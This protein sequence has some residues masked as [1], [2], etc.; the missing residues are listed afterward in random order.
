MT[1][2]QTLQVQSINQQNAGF[3]SELA[4]QPIGGTAV[5]GTPGSAAQSF[6]DK[7][8]GLSASNFPNWTEITTLPGTNTTIQNLIKQLTTGD[9]PNSQGVFS[10]QFRVFTNGVEVVFAFKGSSTLA[11]WIDDLTNSGGNAFLQ[12]QPVFNAVFDALKSDPT[13]ANAQF[14]VDGHSLGGGLA[15][16]F[17]LADDLNGYGQNSLP[18]SATALQAIQI[19][20]PGES[21]MQRVNDYNNGN[22]LQGI[23]AR[24]FVETNTAGDI[25]TLFYSTIQKQTYLNSNPTTLPNP[26]GLSAAI[27]SKI[28]L[29][30]AASAASGSPVGGVSLLAAV[31]LGGVSHLIGRNVNL[32][33]GYSV[34]SNGLL[35]G[36][37]GSVADNGL[38]A[39]Q[40]R[41]L[42]GAVQISD[43]AGNTINLQS[44]GSTGQSNLLSV[45]SN[46][47]PSQQY[48]IATDPNT[49]DLQ[50]DSTAAGGGFLQAT[51]DAS[52]DLLGATARNQDGLTDAIQV[53][54]S[55][56]VTS[57]E[58]ESDGTTPDVFDVTVPNNGSV[59]ATIIATLGAGSIVV[60][61]GT[62]TTTIG[63]GIQTSGDLTWSDSAGTT[64][65]FSGD[66]GSDVG[67]LAISGG[68]LGSNPSSSIVIQNF[69][70]ADAQGSSGFLGIHLPETTFL[71]AS[72]N[73]GIDPPAP[74]FIEGSD[75]S[76]TLSVDAPSTSAQSFAVTLSGASPSDFEATVGNTVEQL[77]A[78]GTF[79]VTLAAGETNVSFGLTDTTADNGSSDISS[80]ATLQ[81]AASLPNPDTVSGGSIQTAPLTFSYIP[82]TP[83]TS[84]APN[85]T[86]VIMGQLDT[87]TGNTDYFGDGGSDFIAAGGGPNF[88]DV[89]N[90][91]GASIIGGAGNNTIYGG[92]GND[93]TSLVGSND[94][95]S[96]G[97]GFNTVYGGTGKDTIYSSNVTT[98]A[99]IINGNNGTDVIIAGDG[100]NE[101]YAGTRTSLANAI[102]AAATATA[103]AT[104]RQGDLI[105]VGDG[106]NTIVGS[107][108][109]DFI[110]S[111]DS[112]QNGTGG[113]DVIVLGA[114]NDTYLGGI[115]V[116]QATGNWS[117]SVS[118]NQFIFN[119]IFISPVDYNNPDAQPYNGNF[120]GGLPVGAGNATIFGG[121]G[122]DLLELA[123]GNNYVEVGS[124]NSSVFGGMGNDTI[125]AGSGT[126]LI[127]GGGG[128]GNATIFSSNGPNGT[129][130]FANANLDQ[131]YVTGGSGSAISIAV[132]VALVACQT[133]HAELPM[134]PEGSI[135]P[136]YGEWEN[137]MGKGHVKMKIAEKWITTLDGWCPQRSR[138]QIVSIGVS[139]I[140]GERSLDIIIKMFGGRSLG[141]VSKTA[142]SIH[143]LDDSY[144]DIYLVDQGMA[145][146]TTIL[147]F[148][149]RACDSLEH[150]KQPIDPEHF[151]V[152]SC[153]A[154]GGIMDRVTKTY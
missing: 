150:L 77:N 73:S 71:N 114:G 44:S 144:L 68:V 101:V 33:L 134:F 29:G 140:E 75:Q 92:S 48:T 31:L 12:V 91:I 16:S 102:A 103:T 76:Y 129:P 113:N 53:S 111:D 49:G 26:P 35:L 139:R 20:S 56:N 18:I 137:A 96:L 119:N 148:G 10:N 90:S 34:G 89:T 99:A 62:N 117:A 4:Y 115:P 21:P 125:I 45:S 136:L 128:T 36:V 46:G 97:G 93:V 78:N 123:N 28:E 124:G 17:A 106:N 122:N 32:S 107:N 132:A 55:G 60:A 154:G 27:N 14:I 151:S 15:Q 127:R 24:A 59:S 69:N 66:V 153:G 112:F 94:F 95:V 80:G 74:N 30:L 142:C 65:T 52:G 67:N 61:N 152:T 110:T 84:S 3:F 143:R 145:P 37:P 54:S 63:N 120:S 135:A 79:N 7:G 2:Q 13:Y 41:A 25:A 58:T 23:V 87:V 22:A 43:G 82:A 8:D 38:S 5:P 39:D 81:L 109:N 83:D 9:T 118:G 100:T 47:N 11:N 57:V 138:Y 121:R 149:W 72:A 42:T 141:K 108:G 98:S 50:L 105:A 1:Q 131:N 40:I 88:I 104:G 116:L 146:D 86:S 19:K 147:A 70:I 51:F 6:A 85:L 64:Y 130:N 133:A 126:D